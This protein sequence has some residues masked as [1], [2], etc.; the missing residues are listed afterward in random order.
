MGV[1]YKAHDEKLDRDVALKFFP[2]NLGSDKADTARF[3]QEAKAAAALNHPNICTIHA[4]KEVDGNKFIV[5]ELV[6]GETLRETIRRATS[7]VALQL[8]D[9]ISYSVQIAEALH[10]AHSHGIIHRDI[11]SENIMVNSTN[12]I[13]VMDFGL[14]KLRGSFHLTKTS[15]TVGTV[16]YMA[17]EMTQG[18]DADARS[19]IFSFGIVLYEMEGC[20]QRPARLC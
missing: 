4:I 17:P 6:D 14:A 8:N 1:V 12:Q 9:A 10:E 15:S 7:L 16:A 19:D 11:K 2:H 13:K 5:M 18:G 20:R 3:I